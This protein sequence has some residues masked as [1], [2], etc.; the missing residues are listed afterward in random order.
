[1]QGSRWAFLWSL[2]ITV[3]HPC[4]D[5]LS[6]SPL[7]LSFWSS[8]MKIFSCCPGGGTG[9]GDQLSNLPY[10]CINDCS[11][12]L[13]HVMNALIKS[14][15]SYIKMMKL[16]SLFVKMISWYTYIIHHIC[17]NILFYTLILQ[18]IIILMIDIVL[19]ISG[20]ESI[21]IM[22]IHLN[23]IWIYI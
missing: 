12:L 21:W 4:F 19:I 18:M 9:D 11:C 6:F 22:E 10:L 16:I 20:K 5:D 8:I 7:Y 13:I 17:I 3:F 23:C 2:I 14:Q 15:N 1:M